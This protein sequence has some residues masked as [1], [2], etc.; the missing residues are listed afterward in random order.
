[1]FG[2]KYQQMLANIVLK[3]GHQLPMLVS[4]IV[5]EFIVYVGQS[6]TLADTF[7]CKH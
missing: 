3:H 1:M 4:N 6:K 7:H 2:Q 5:N